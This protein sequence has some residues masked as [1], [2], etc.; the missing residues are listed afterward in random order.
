MCVNLALGPGYASMGERALGPTW[1]ETGFTLSLRSFSS[2]LRTSWIVVRMT[3]S[4]IGCGTEVLHLVKTAASAPELERSHFF[5]HASQRRKCNAKT[6]IPVSDAAASYQH[7]KQ[8]LKGLHAPA[9]FIPHGCSHCYCYLS[10]VL[11]FKI[12]LIY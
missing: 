9:P 1:W 12:C 4:S 3:G 11:L 6:S 5:T 10:R 8:T 7:P 2:T